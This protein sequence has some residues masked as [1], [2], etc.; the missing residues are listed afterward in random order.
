MLQ[1][2]SQ[3]SR[4]LVGLDGVD[5]LYALKPLLING[6]GQIY[7][8][9][10]IPKSLVFGRVNRTLA[11]NLTWLALVSSLAT[12][13]AW[14]IGSKFVVG[15]VKVRTEAEEARAR[16][17]AIVESSEDAVIGM[18]L[19]GVVTSWNAG[20]ESMYGYRTHE[21]VGQP[22]ERLIPPELRDEVGDLLE[23]VKLGRGINRYESKRMRKNG[24]IFDVSASLSP[25][26]D[27]AGKV[28]G[29]A[30]ITRDVTLLRKGEEQLLAY[31]DQLENLNSLSQDIAGTLSVDAVVERSL[32]RIV[33]TSG[34]DF[35]V[36]RFSM[37]VAGRTFY[38][39]GRSP[40]SQIDLEQLWSR[41]GVDFEQCFWECRN[42]WF[43]EDVAATPE[44]AMAAQNNKIKSLAVLPL[45][46]GD[47]PCATLALLS[48]E[49]H[50]FG[51]EEKQ[52]L[53]TTAQQIALAVEN[54]RLYGA[55]VQANGDL[56]REI[57]ERKRAEQT[58][59]DFAAMV[60]HDLR[61]PLSNVVSITD[62]IREGLFGPVTD[63]QQKWL[64]K[65]QESCRSL[66]GHVSD[67]LDLS[68]IDAGKLQLTRA[69]MDVAALL[70]E[71]LLEYSVEAEKRKINLKM[72]ISEGLP[73]LSI[74][75]RRINQVLDNLLSNAFKFTDVGGEVE[76]AARRYHDSDVVLWVKDSG[77]GI[78]ED[79][80][81]AIFDKYRQVT[82]GR[83]SNRI[84]TGLGLA[85]CK[86]IIEAHGGRIWVESRPGTG[87][88]FFVS[89][90]LNAQEPSYATPA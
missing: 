21:I 63:M 12:G 26:R 9:V 69:S 84:G 43:V 4:D 82:T 6:G 1:L 19:D 66:I 62:S 27:L 15:Y 41:L 76:V 78:P 51:A 80:I 83:S 79:E 24:Q 32:S 58:L 50:M 88:C 20:A 36:V 68:K 44:L 22:I 28:V 40:C 3:I 60:A 39:V 53:Q 16:L 72:E 42:P 46:H 11:R 30:T 35:A 52:F 31:T 29:A 8:M 33:S 25:V 18:R 89:L 87:S 86:K 54:A 75:G 57:E 48:A 59:A 2:R 61:S 10:G 55:S 37:E 34:C 38:G 17:A 64:W 74:D 85:I 77:I 65:V 45:T 56:R 70:Q 23:I 81:A 7:V 47:S 14:L 13:F 67:F 90:P 71:R 49:A 5:R 73:L